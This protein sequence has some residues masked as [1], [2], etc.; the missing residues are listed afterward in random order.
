MSN[1]HRQKLAALAVLLAAVACNKKSGSTNPYTTPGPVDAGFGGGGADASGE[2]AAVAVT[3]LSPAEGSIASTAAAVEVRVRIVLSGG[4]TR[5]RDAYLNPSSLRAVLIP[6]SQA[7]LAGA[8][9]ISATPLVPGTVDGEYRGKL[10]VQ[11]LLSG[12]YVLRAMGA[13][14]SGARGEAEVNIRLDAGPVITVLSPQAGA[15]YKGTMT[16][17]VIVDSAPH[18]PTMLPL[19][20]VIGGIPVAVAQVGTSDTFRGAIDFR[21]PIPPL[22]GEQLLSVAAKNANGTRSETRTIF[23]VDEAGPVITN[24]VPVPGDVVGGVIHIA[25]KIVDDAGVL[26][27]SISVLIGNVNDPKFKLPLM[28]EGGGVY[29]TLFDTAKLTGCRLPPDTGL[30]IVFPTLSFRAADLLGNE[31]VVSYEIAVDNEP[32]LLDLDPPAIRD[33]KIDKGALRCSWTFDPLSNNSMNGDMPRDGCAVSQVFDL[34]AR[35]QDTS[36]V[37][38]GLKIGPISGLNPDTIAVYVLDDTTQPLAVDGDGDGVCDSINPRLVP[39][40]TPPTQNNQV[41]K[42]RLSPVTRKGDADF[43]PDPSLIPTLAHPPFCYPGADTDPPE[44]PCDG[45]Q[46]TIVITYADGESAIWSVDP[47]DQRFCEGGQFDTYANKISEG[48][49]CIAVAGSDNNGNAGVS[50]PLRVF[51]SYTLPYFPFC[52]APPASAGPPPDCTGRFDKASGVVNN[53]ACK[54][55]RFEDRRT[56]DVP[57][58]VC[59]RGDC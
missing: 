24:T 26:P 13:T 31:S 3:I 49:A 9:E 47:I 51:I 2:P 32:P 17:E 29:G 4:Q 54:P 15:H 7:Q 12:E 25:A 39:T 38:G 5:T 40:T 48:W 8:D 23:V 18:T 19:E 46:P 58:E 16:V 52:P 42:V 41:L 6:G 53:V 11:T 44:A 35:V 45:N 56:A 55:R 21:K 59:Y 37:A 28:D 14:P 22:V 1:L 30:C 33:S 43:T 34:R 50:A 27:S 10:N 36:N 57:L 20:V